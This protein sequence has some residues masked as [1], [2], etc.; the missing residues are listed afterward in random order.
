MM[1]SLIWFLA[2]LNLWQNLIGIGCSVTAAILFMMLLK[3]R[4]LRGLPKYGR[5]LV[6]AIPGIGF[7]VCAVVFGLNIAMDINRENAPCCKEIVS[8]D[9][10][11]VSDVESMRIV[12]CGRQTLLK[13]V[14]P[15]EGQGRTMSVFTGESTEIVNVQFTWETKIGWN[16][17][18]E[19]CEI[20]ISG[21]T[22]KGWK[23][24]GRV[25]GI[26][27]RSAM[28]AGANI[29]FKLQKDG[30]EPTLLYWP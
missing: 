11:E 8:I 4:F 10:S 30:S 3:S 9:S 13:R 1:D 19:P 2:G 28:R 29:G 25:E 6:G 23:V 18:N 21:L 14:S 16:F 22:D 24:L 5:V 26:E 7:S 27:I 20:V 12:L 15:P 17:H